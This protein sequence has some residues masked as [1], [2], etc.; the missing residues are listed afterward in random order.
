MAYVFEGIANLVNIEDFDVSFD[1]DGVE[2]SGEYIY[3][4]ITNSLS[5]FTFKK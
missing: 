3:G 1:A 2:Y 4:G 5:V